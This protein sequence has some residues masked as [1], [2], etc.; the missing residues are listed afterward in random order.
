MI[1]FYLLLLSLPFVEHGFFGMAIGPLT[2]EKLIGA[3]CFLYAITYLPQRREVPR[4]FA[5]PQAKA[6][7]LYVGLAVVSYL[8]TAE[9]F[10]FVDLI[11]VFFSQLVFFV[12][13]MILVDSRERLEATVVTVTASVGIVSLYLIREW[14]GNVGAYGISYRP[15][16]VAGDPN[17]FSASAL[18]VLPIML[19]PIRYAERGWQRL[20]AMFSLFVTLVAFVLAASRGGMLGL[21]CMSLWHMHDWR[22][23][24]IALLVIAALVGGAFLLPSSPLDRLL[25][26]NESDVESSNI[27]LQ[28]WTASGLIFR[29]HPIFGV[30]LYNFP[31]YLH[32][33][34]PPGVDLEFVVPHNTYLEA[35]VEL[36]L[37]GLLLF[38]SVIGFTLLS[39]S[40][41]RHAAIAAGD[42]YYTA[43]A[44]GVGSGI[45]GFAVAVF[46]LSAKHA[47]LFWFSVFLS[48]CMAPIM[49]HSFR[50]A[51]EK[52]EKSAESAPQSV[53]DEL[54]AASG[55]AA[56]VETLGVAS[57]DL[58]STG[59]EST[60]EERPTADGAAPENPKTDPPP[61]RVGNWL[62]RH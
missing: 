21:M 26:P 22:R 49:E 1:I 46:F 10:D 52:E 3:A 42:A 37:V 48:A 62:S 11:G 18:L 6:F 51:R 59:A 47:K 44:T 8:A 55:D 2:M 28:L 33:Y 9:T 54:V 20:G 27:R 19:C 50:Q 4:F 53:Q 45:V 61:I 43:L 13:V 14:V 29:D 24:M 16:F 34:L 57:T 35:L 12:T 41:L 36:G 38:L 60:T 39:L 40:R 32:Q 30:G 17:V 7:A 23:R 15:G 5:S 31:K 25:K 58:E 56:S